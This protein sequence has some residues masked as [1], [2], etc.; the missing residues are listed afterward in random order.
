[1]TDGRQPTA[2][3]EAGAALAAPGRDVLSL[4]DTDEGPLKGKQDR[5]QK[6]AHV[7]LCVVTRAEL[8]SSKLIRFVA[9]PDHQIVPDLAG[10]LPGRGVWVTATRAAVL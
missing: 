1:V 5:S 8:P 7:R 6:R 2:A 10:R 4:S 3:D 9:G